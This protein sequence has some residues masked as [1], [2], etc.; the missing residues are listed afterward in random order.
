MSN[1]KEIVTKAVV[2]KGRKAS[3]ND[4]SI[5]T[6]NT[7]ST[8]LG[9]WIINHNFTGEKVDDSVKVVGSFDTNIWYSTENNTKTEVAKEKVTY[10]ELIPIK[11][12]DDYDNQDEIIVRVIKQP[13]CTKA[14]IKDNNIEYTIEK[15]L[16]AELVGDTKIRVGID[17]INEQD[18]LE[19]EI[20]DEIKEDFIK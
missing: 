17:D 18:P 2:G 19:E 5:K 13:S 7:P 1:F 3:I 9:C 8:I 14:E 11:K 4:Y 15:T 16:A 10:E 20:S 12:S 6:D